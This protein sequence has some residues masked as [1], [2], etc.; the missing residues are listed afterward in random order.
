MALWD[1]LGKARAEPVWKILGYRESYRKIPYASQLFGDTPEQTRQ[2]AINARKQN[3]R[4]VKFGWGPIGKSTLAADIDQFMAAREG[5]GPDGIL[6]VD[7]GQ[8]FGDD[9]DA[10]AARS[11]SL[12]QSRALWFEEPFQ[13]YALEAYG[14][15]ASRSGKVKLAGGEGA[16]NFHM[17]KHLIDYGYVGYIQIDCGRIGRHWRCQ[18][19]CR[20]CH[21]SGRDVRQPHFHFASR[22]QR[23]FLAALRG[24]TCSRNLRVSLRSESTCSRVHREPPGARRRRFHRCAGGPRLGDCYRF[25]IRAEVSGGCRD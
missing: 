8:V 7:T 1:L 12:E 3:F 22:A 13:T 10:A 15:L 14:S 19:S 5:L 2:L 6:L 21:S 11:P 16:H 18:A 24:V 17:A 9:L 20:L 4:A 25:R 23:S